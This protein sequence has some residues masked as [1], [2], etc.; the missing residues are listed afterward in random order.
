MVE[1]EKYFK[2][3]SIRKQVCPTF[4]DVELDL[5]ASTQSLPDHGVPPAIISAAMPMD[6]LHTFHP[7]LDGPATVRAATCQLPEE[8]KRVEADDLEQNDTVADDASEVPGD[9]KHPDLDLPAEYIIGVQEESGDDAVNRMAAF[10]RQIQLV[11]EHGEAICKFERQ[12][13]K[14]KAATGAAKEDSAN[15]VVQAAAQAAAAK[16]QHGSG[17]C[18]CSTHQ[19]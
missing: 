6:T 5:H 8:D 9:P 11:T 14:H 3:V 13:A 7:T 1:R 18:R 12:K 4:A 19:R 17:Q 2:C 10:Q 16:A 15:D